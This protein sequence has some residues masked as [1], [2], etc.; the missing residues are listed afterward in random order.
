MLTYQY[1]TKNGQQKT[2]SAESA[3]AA[4]RKAPDADLHLGGGF[5][6]ISS[7][8]QPVASQ[9]AHSTTA[10][11]QSQAT[12]SNL[13]GQLDDPNMKR[14]IGLLP[15]Q[16]QG[17]LSQVSSS[18]AKR[19]EAG[20]VINPSINLTPADTSKLLRQATNEIDPYYREQIDFVKQD[21]D[22]SLG[23]L[24]E[25]FNTFASRQKTDYS[26]AQKTQANNEANSGTA[27][28]SGRAQ[29]ETQLADQATRQLTDAQQYATRQAQA[30]GTNAERRIGSN[31]LGNF[32]LP[33]YAAGDNGVYQSGGRSLNLGSNNVTGSLQ[34][35][36]DVA[37]KNRSSQLQGA[38][39]LSRNLDLRPLQ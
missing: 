26:Q 30:F 21:L 31:Q 4:L 10:P 39:R 12:N 15:P 2:V 33:S 35:E 1:T 7:Q 20:Q 32:S 37:I 23:V 29:R 13:F 11:V 6:L 18:V 9:A 38:F 19:I 36:R 5:R 28:S 14:L 8:P 24:Q 27:F 16:L 17:A 34:K 3:S 25:D 22:R